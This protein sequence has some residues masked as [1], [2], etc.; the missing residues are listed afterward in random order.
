MQNWQCIWGYEALD[1]NAFPIGLEQQLQQLEIF[2]FPCCSAFRIRFQNTWGKEALPIAEAWLSSPEDN[3]ETERFPITVEQRSCFSIAPGAVCWSDP[4]FAS[5]RAGQ[6]LCLTLV[7]AQRCQVQSA[8]TF[9]ANSM[10]KVT[11]LHLD[12]GESGNPAVL[13]S[14]FTQKQPAHHCV[15]GI[16]RVAVLTEENVRTVAAFGDSITHMSRWTAP[17]AKRMLEVYKGRMV[18]M[19]CGICGNRLL[20]DASTGSGQGSW[21]GRGGL[22]RFEKDLF[23]NGFSADCI[24]LLEGIN[25]ILHPAIGEAPPEEFESAGAIVECLEICA[26]IAHQRGARIYVCTLMPFNGCK[27]HWRP[28]L[29]EKRCRVNELLKCS[30]AFDGLFDFDSWT[31]A[32]LD[33][34]RLNPADGSE[35]NLH[36]GV[37]GGIK[38]AQR[39]DLQLLS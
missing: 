26:R 32:P 36:P 6:K 37:K 8:C 15:M 38:I 2:N 16:D 17:L 34:T 31:R 30:T 35:D 23:E 12:A 1:F 24:I 13:Q 21:F 7:F 18:L 20:H 14:V 39:I 4:V 11:H 5:M 19:N 28:W 10:A 3:K 22:K 9:L 29:E 33:A 27:D 25:D